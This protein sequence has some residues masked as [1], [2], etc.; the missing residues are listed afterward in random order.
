MDHTPTQIAPLHF[1]CQKI[2]P[3]VFDDSLSYYE[4]LC[5]LTDKVNE[6]INTRDTTIEE[7]QGA[8]RELY[9]YVHGTAW[10]SA[11]ERWVYDNLPCIMTAVCQWFVFSVNDNGNIVVSIPNSWEWAHLNWDMDFDSDTFGHFRI[12][13]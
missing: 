9:E 8:L 6:I 11:I 7:L 10:E 3:A 13:W 5:R 12:G 2:L 1:Y 4:Q